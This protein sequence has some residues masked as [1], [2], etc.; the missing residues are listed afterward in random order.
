MKNNPTGWERPDFDDAHLVK[1]GLCFTNLYLGIK[2]LFTLVWYGWYYTNL[3]LINLGS[4]QNIFHSVSY[5]FLSGT[6]KIM[7]WLEKKWPLKRLF[8]V[9]FCGLGSFKL[10]LSAFAWSIG[11]KSTFSATLPWKLFS[12]PIPRK[13]FPKSIWSGQGVTSTP[14]LVGQADV[15]HNRQLYLVKYGWY[16]TKGRVQKHR[17]N[18]ECCPVP[19]LIVRQQR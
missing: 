3:Y 2:L 8:F 16:L 13:M 17:K 18:C 7:I 9:T 14:A 6:F 12:A 1:Y 11:D 4:R 19:Q 15:F 10:F 5:D